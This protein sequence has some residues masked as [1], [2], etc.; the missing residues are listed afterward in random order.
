MVFINPQLFASRTVALSTC[1]NYVPV[2]LAA[3]VDRELVTR[4]CEE[5]EG[6]ITLPEVQDLLDQTPGFHIKCS[7]SIPAGPSL[8]V[9]LVAKTIRDRVPFE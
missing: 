1:V 3:L 5:L 2:V 4:I 9:L 7:M 8:T 6:R